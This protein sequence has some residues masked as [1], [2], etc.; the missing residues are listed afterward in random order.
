MTTL[1]RIIFFLRSVFKSFIVVVQAFGKF[2][3]SSFI[4]GGTPN[5]STTAPNERCA[6]NELITRGAIAVDAEGKILETSERNQ[7]FVS[8]KTLLQF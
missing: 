8:Q 7:E 3:R 4:L 2:T 5:L 6:N 1:R